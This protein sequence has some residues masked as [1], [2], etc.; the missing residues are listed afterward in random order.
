MVGVRSYFSRALLKLWLWSA[1]GRSMVV[2]T[3]TVIND[4][5]TDIELNLA[6]YALLKDWIAYKHWANINSSLNKV[7]VNPPLS[8]LK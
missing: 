4:F 2:V 3:P 1:Y 7:D 6:D 8:K 5:K